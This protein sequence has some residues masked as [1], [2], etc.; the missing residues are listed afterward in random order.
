MFCESQIVSASLQEAL[1]VSGI[2]CQSL[3]V[4][5]VLDILCESLEVIRS[6][7]ES[8]RVFGSL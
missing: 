7:W 2:V 8:L 1:G 6:V 5:R 4:S 3:G